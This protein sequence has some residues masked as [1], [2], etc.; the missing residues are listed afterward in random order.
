MDEEIFHF[1]DS[2]TLQLQKNIWKGAPNFSF[3]FSDGWNNDAGNI[4]AITAEILGLAGKLD[5]LVQRSITNLYFILLGIGRESWN[6]MN[7]NYWSEINV[8]TLIILIILSTIITKINK[9]QPFT[10]FLLC[11]SHLSYIHYCTKTINENIL[12]LFSKV[13]KVNLKEAKYL[14]FPKVS[15]KY[16][17]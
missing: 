10:E 17:N 15:P 4:A 7:T 16:Q 3:S 1:M 5:V 8:C 12:F 13:K 14:Y 11:A 6:A 2:S 9:S